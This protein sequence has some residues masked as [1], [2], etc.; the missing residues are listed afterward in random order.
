MFPQAYDLL[1]DL[2][3]PEEVAAHVA[4]GVLDTYRDAASHSQI[5]GLLLL[6]PEVDPEAPLLVRHIVHYVRDAAMTHGI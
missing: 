5:V 1:H 3:F 6:H 2:G 4:E